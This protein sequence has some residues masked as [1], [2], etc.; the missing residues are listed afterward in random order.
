MRSPHN[1]VSGFE[2]EALNE[3]G[4]EG[5]MEELDSIGMDVELCNY[6]LSERTIIRAVIQNR[7]TDTKLKTFVRHLI[8][9]VGTC[10]AGMYVYY[11]NIYWLIV[12]I[13][14]D[15][16][17]YEKAILSNCN[18]L[19]SWVDDNGA[20]VQRWAN[21]TSASQYNNGETATYNYHIRSDQLLIAIPDDDASLLLHQGMRFIIDRRCRVYEKSIDSSVD[22]DTSNPVITYEITRV[23][24]VL[25][26]YQSSG[27]QEIMVT[28]DE[29]HAGDGYYRIGDTGYWLCREPSESTSPL[30]CFIDYDE[31][32]IYS[33]LD[34]AAFTAVFYDVDGNVVDVDPNWLLDCS[35][36]DDLA[37]DYI[38][39]TILIGADD[40][41]LVNKSFT[42]ILEND[43]YKRQE[44]NITVRA[45]I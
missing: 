37:I 15:N 24:N 16:G 22:V 8:A 45:F 18:Y 3:F 28:Q 27:H 12:G 7:L 36:E 32:A 14:D 29:Q 5:I 33:G 26:D 34:A 25:Y 21:V 4:E 43:G 17:L 9:P 2:S 19:L 1:Q 35:F 38:N 11:K 40:P 23:D 41:S 10:K 30:S 44:V 6:D 42:L 39:N 13:V 31:D 20:V